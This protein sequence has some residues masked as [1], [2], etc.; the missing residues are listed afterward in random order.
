MKTPH[1]NND[2]QQ[3]TWSQQCPSSPTTNTTNYQ[4]PNYKGEERNS[5]HSPNYWWVGWMLDSC[6]TALGRRKIAI[7]YV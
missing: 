3:Q 6:S 1:T 2:I 7:K 4:K 5:Q